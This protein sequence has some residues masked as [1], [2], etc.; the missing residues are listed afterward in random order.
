MAMFK[1]KGVRKDNGEAVSAK[2]EAADAESAR[3]R[4]GRHGIDV[5]SVEPMEL[6]PVPAPTPIPVEAERAAPLVID[7]PPPIP[8][9]AEPW[10]QFVADGQDPATVARLFESVRQILTSNEQL[11]YIG[12]QKKPVMNVKPDAVALTSRRVI[13]YFAKLIGTSFE[14]FQWIDLVDAKLT[15]G[16]LGATLTFRHVNG[17]EVS[18]DYLPKQQARALYRIAQEQEEAARANR[19]AH[20]LED[21][22]AAAGTP[23]VAIMAG[24]P[25]VSMMQPPAP[26]APPPAA[27]PDLATRMQTLKQLLDAGLISQAEFDAKRAE[28]LRA[29]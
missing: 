6:A 20:H 28:I 17:R 10:R 3:A 12:V 25:G 23:Q 24:S 18:I 27:A 11:L 4:A 16:M 2:V 22:R 13:V 26:V 7:M 14:D 5:R 15:E 9:S 8:R 19:R 29:I 1:V 21:A